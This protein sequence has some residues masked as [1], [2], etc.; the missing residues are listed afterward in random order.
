MNKEIEKIIDSVP[1]NLVDERFEDGKIEVKELSC[2]YK[3]KFRELLNKAFEK[4][5]NKAVEEGKKHA[6]IFP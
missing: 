3:E 2:F 5:K 1:W 6:Q 4:G